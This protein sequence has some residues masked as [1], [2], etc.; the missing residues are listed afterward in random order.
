M[1][2]N[3][4]YHVLESLIPPAPSEDVFIQKSV[5][6]LENTCAASIAKHGINNKTLSLSQT[7]AHL[8]FLKYIHEIKKG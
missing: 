4:S 6:R 7:P 1:F 5:L 3:C 2:G 8:Q